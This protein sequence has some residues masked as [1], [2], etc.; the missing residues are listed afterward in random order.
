[1]CRKEA[2]SDLAAEG[3]GDPDR[4]PDTSTAGVQIPEI[5]VDAPRR[6]NQLLS[7]VI[8]RSE[9]VDGAHTER[10]ADIQGL[11]AVAVIAVLV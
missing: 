4:E 2:L 10:R 5:P 6:G 1:M 3:R 9:R 11:R 7:D 8:S